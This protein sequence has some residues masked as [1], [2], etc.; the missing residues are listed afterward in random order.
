MEYQQEFLDRDGQRLGIQLYPEPD[1][2]PGPTPEPV[3]GPAPSNP[4]PLA[5]VLPAMGAPARFY[6][7]F[8]AYLRD[9]GFAVAVADL[10]GIGSS[11]PRPGRTSAYG[12]ADLVDDLPAVLDWLGRRRAG[13]PILLVGH[14]LGGLVGLLHLGLTNDRSVDGLV[15]IGS[16]LP[17]WRAYPFPRRYRVRAF[18]RSVGLLARLIGYWPGWTFGGRQS[19]GVISDWAG[20]LCFNQ[21]P[22]RAGVDGEAAF[23][24]MSTPVLS[25]TIEPDPLL[26][27]SATEHTLAR[28]SSAR[29]ERMVFSGTDAPGAQVDHFR[30]VPVSGAIAARIAAFA[31]ATCTDQ[32][33]D[34]A[35]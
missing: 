10:R 15:L 6:R 33:T 4:A 9:V 32:S 11:T 17:Y 16:G 2:V 18:A 34:L 28:L 29:V 31:R 23:A 1:P 22:V 13:R 25:V 35:T 24:R 12:I 26:P 7:P 8:A 14:S 21:V 27:T 5:L 30:W 20:C 19:L 3:S